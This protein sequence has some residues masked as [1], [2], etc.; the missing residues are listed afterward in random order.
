VVVATLWPALAAGRAATRVLRCAPVPATRTRKAPTTTSTDRLVESLISLMEAGTTPWRREWD[1]STG[2]H[3]LNL[4]TGHRYRGTNPVLLTLVMHLRGSVLPYWCG[5]A[6]ANA[7]GLLPR[8]GSQAVRILR[9]QVHKGSDTPD[10][11]PS[12]EPENNN[13]LRV[14]YRPV[15]VFNAADLVGP[16]LDE[17]I[18]QR[19]GGWLVPVHH[20]GDRACYIPSAD[21]IRLPQRTA[22]HSCGAYDATWAHEICGSG[23]CRQPRLPRTRPSQRLVPAALYCAPHPQLPGRLGSSMEAGRAIQWAGCSAPTPPPMAG[24]RRRLGDLCVGA[25]SHQREGADGDGVG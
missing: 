11:E 6:E 4:L 23:A 14:S 17:L 8:K 16:G 2:G 5:Y 21:Q 10:S 3:H 7:A 24:R 15:P 13:S 22:F 9:P 18:C 25:Q 19:R 20:G 1:A 12:Q